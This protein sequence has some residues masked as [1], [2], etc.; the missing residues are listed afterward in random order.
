MYPRLSALRNHTIA[1]LAGLG[2]QLHFPCRCCSLSLHPKAVC[3]QNNS[4]IQ[5]AGYSGWSAG[6]S[7]F[8]LFN[9]RTLKVH[10]LHQIQRF[11]TLWKMVSK[12]EQV[13]INGA[14]GRRI[15]F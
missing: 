14:T 8:V 10:V 3:Q 13:H 12:S 15:R 7:A 11:N 1:L 9:F 4:Q 2:D 5:L 6:G